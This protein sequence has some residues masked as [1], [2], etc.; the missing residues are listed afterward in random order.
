MKAEKQMLSPEDVSVRYSISKGTL[1][2]WRSRLQGPRFYKVGKRKVLYR[3]DDIKN[4]F[5]SSPVQTLDSVQ[6]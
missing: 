4:Y 5:E 1:A 6:K 2:N 3:S